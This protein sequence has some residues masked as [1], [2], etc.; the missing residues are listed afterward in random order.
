MFDYKSIKFLFVFIDPVPQKKSTAKVLRVLSETDL[1]ATGKRSA[2]THLPNSMNNWFVM[3]T[4]QPKKHSHHTFTVE[5]GDDSKKN[6]VVTD[7]LSQTTTKNGSERKGWPS[8]TGTMT[9]QQHNLISAAPQIIHDTAHNASVLSTLPPGH[10]K[11]FNK[12]ELKNKIS[13]ELL[14]ESK[15][16][17]SPITSRNSFLQN[18]HDINQPNVD[19]ENIQHR[20]PVLAT[21]ALMLRFV[22]F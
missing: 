9:I 2:N 12:N 6:Y 14:K 17:I 7:S 22:L 10:F 5:N 16:V 13:L 4:D 8:K 18:W 15:E 21:K 11:N 20:V 19:I 1:Q 3:N